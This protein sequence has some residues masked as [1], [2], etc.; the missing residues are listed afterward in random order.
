MYNNAVLFDSS[1]VQKVE[2]MTIYH[3]I[4]LAKCALKAYTLCP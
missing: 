4:E 3:D 1:Y 2:L